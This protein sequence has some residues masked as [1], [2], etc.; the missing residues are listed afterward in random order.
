[1]FKKNI[2][3]TKI[4]KLLKTRYEIVK[5][6][7]HQLQK[8]NNQQR[9][10]ITKRDMWLEKNMDDNFKIKEKVKEIF[11]LSNAISELETKQKIQDLCNQII[12]GDDN[13]YN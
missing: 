7:K 5:H 3:N 6:Q 11:F 13:D 9:G 1:M 12:E 10:I 2:F 4:Y 8:L